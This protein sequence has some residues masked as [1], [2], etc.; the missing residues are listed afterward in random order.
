MQSENSRTFAPYL[1][2]GAITHVSAGRDLLTSFGVALCEGICFNFSMKFTPTKSQTLDMK[3][4]SEECYTFS[5]AHRTV[6]MESEGDLKPQ[7]LLLREL[8]RRTI[9]LRASLISLAYSS[10]IIWRLALQP[11]YTITCLFIEIK[12]SLFL[13]LDPTFLLP[14]L[15]QKCPLVPAA[16]TLS[17][18]CGSQY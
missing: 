9:A 3:S 2:V 4:A 8:L 15:P 12:T 7:S 16:G 6:E 14:S 11:S 5:K 10:A 18:D 17:T 1:H 13:E